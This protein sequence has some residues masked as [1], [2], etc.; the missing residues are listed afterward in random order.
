VLNTILKTIDLLIRLLDRAALKQ[1][2]AGSSLYKAADAM[3][4]SADEV[5]AKGDA[6]VDNGLRASAL[7]KKLALLAQE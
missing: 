7:A 2:A 6:L 5:E 3:R 4:D 1:I